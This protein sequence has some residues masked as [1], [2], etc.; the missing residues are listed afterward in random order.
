M[1]FELFL[2]PSF[3]VTGPFTI[4]FCLFIVFVDALLCVGLCLK[5]IKLVDASIIISEK[6]VK[7]SNCKINTITVYQTQDTKRQQP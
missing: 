6:V 4:F 1:Y 7:L 2:I 3:Y 5:S